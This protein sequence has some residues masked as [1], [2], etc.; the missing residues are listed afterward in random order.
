MWELDHLAVTA[1]TLAEAADHVAAA[2]GV[3][4]GPVGQHAHMGTHN[5][6]VG[7]G[8]SDYLEAIAIDPEAPVP[9]WPRWFRLSEASAGPRL[10]NWICRVADLEAALG[11]APQGAGVPTALSRGD[12]R[13]R[14]AVP[15]DGRL[16]FD[17]SFP[18]LL[19]WTGGLKPSDRLPDS[20]CRLARLEVAHPDADHLRALLQLSDPRIEI[21]PG[22]PALRAT[23]D[24]PGGRR[25][26]Q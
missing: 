19:S 8:P 24:T 15:A 20:G 4:L 26:L 5:R 18:A 16:P 2:L 12:F 9:A 11:A 6:L 3:S 10:T 23:F 1:P 21:V 17:D 14:M 7:L 22:A 25:R 13:W